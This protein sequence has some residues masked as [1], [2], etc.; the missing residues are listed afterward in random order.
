V[1]ASADRLD[2]KTLLIELK[3]GDLANACHVLGGRLFRPVPAM[4]GSRRW[5][6]DEFIEW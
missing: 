4:Y 3:E 1:S 2:K 6:A 5:G